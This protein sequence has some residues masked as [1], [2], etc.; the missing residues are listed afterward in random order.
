MKA[1]NILYGKRL[2]NFLLNILRIL[3]FLYAFS[4]ILMLIFGF[5]GLVTDFDMTPPEFPVLFS[6]INEG[7]FNDLGGQASNFKLH[8]G[9]GYIGMENPPNGIVIFTN[10][11]WL[12][13]M[14]GMLISMKQ[15]IFIL[16]AA[17][18][19]DFLINENAIRLRWIALIGIALFLLEKTYSIFTYVYFSDRLELS[20][21][22]FESFNTFA[23]MN[24][25]FI[26][27]SLFLLVIAEAFRV[28]SQLKE[29][30][31]LTI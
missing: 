4:A 19:G 3:F 6:V 31:E 12:L 14:I 24:T 23:F 29:E 17:K 1:L 13:V 27:Y 5:F 15:T 8:G 18:K 16:E 2:I 11:I 25:E 7:S 22:S 10:I 30:T 21:V 20:G 28:G 26:F 9:L